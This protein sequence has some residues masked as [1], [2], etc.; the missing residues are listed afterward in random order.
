MRRSPGFTLIEV[1]VAVAIVA[2]IGVIG[3]TGLTRVIDQQEVAEARAERW[4]EIQ[5]A[6]RIIV[7]DLSQAHPRVTRDETG[8]A[9]VESFLADPTHQ[10][11]LEFS[12]GGWSNPTGFPRGTVLRVAYDIEGDLLVRFYWPVADRTLSTPPGRNEVLSGVLDMQVT[13]I[14]ALG[15]ESPDWPP[16]NNGQVTAGATE[17]PRAVRLMLDIE[18]LGEIWRLVEVSS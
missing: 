18:G 6:M 12:R 16:L 8:S 1:L 2:I 11:A 17:R 5:L 13:Y 4:R 15:N 3:L 9:P 10:F 14:D 7:Q